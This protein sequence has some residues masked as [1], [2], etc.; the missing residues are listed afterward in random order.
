[1]SRFLPLFL[2]GLA[3]A[4]LTSGTGP[5]AA[6]QPAAGRTPDFDA[7]AEETT[8]RLAEYLRIRT[9]NPPGNETAG[10]RWLQHVLRGEGIESEIFESSPGRGN[11]YA[12]LRGNGKRRPIVLLSHIDVVPATAS[13]WKVAPWAGKIHDGQVWGRGAL[14]M[15][16]MAIVELMTLIALERR[17]VPLSRDIILIANA[18]EETGST[19]A[20]WFARE[21]SE[22][23][24]DAEFL[25][26]EGGSNQLGRDGK[27]EYYGVAVTEKLPYWLRL[28]VRGSPGHGSIPRPDNAAARLARAL[29]RIGGH[30]TPLQVTPPAA[31]FFRDLSTRES[32]PQRR[33]WLAD[34]ARALREP[35]GR[36]FFT[37]NLYFNALLRNTISVTVMQGSNKTNVI[38]PEASAELDVRLL[39]GTAPATFL[40]ELR[41]V[42][43]D[44]TVEITPLRPDREASTSPLRGPLID[45][46]RETVQA[47]DPGALITTPMLAGYTDSYYYRA[48]GIG[49]YGLDPF[50]VTEAEDQ[51][52]HGNDERVSLANIRFGVEFFYR[53][54]E[55][56]AR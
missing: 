8:R 12:R 39:P 38:P 22:L 40:A 13:A 24:R 15:K 16:G 48:L 20:E 46:I 7:L 29:G 19:G 47:M 45:A 37:S 54:V 17:G 25:I 21:K 49:A 2:V 35:E 36:R 34:P 43:A 32:D 26:N 28:T 50:R 23:I 41:R 5:V 11:L 6:Q 31:Q 42:I 14:D 3:A 51:T 55:R 27:I 53:V 52:V 9:V 1:M 18:D 33:R 10:A 30:E 4:Q 56:V 44:T